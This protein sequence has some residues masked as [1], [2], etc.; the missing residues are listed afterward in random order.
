MAH[1]QQQEQQQ[2]PPLSLIEQQLME[3]QQQQDSMRRQAHVVHF[4][5]PPT[6]LAQ[7][8]AVAPAATVLSARQHPGVHDAGALPAFINTTGMQPQQQDAQQ[9][10]LKRP[11][12]AEQQVHSEARTSQQALLPGI[13]PPGSRGTAAA[14]TAHARAAAAAAQLRQYMAQLM[15]NSVLPKQ[16][17]YHPH[18]QAVAH[19]AA[20]QPFLQAALHQQLQ[21]H[22]LQQQHL[23]QQHQQ[24]QHQQQQQQAQAST[25]PQQ[26]RPHAATQQPGRQFVGSSSDMLQ[27]YATALGYGINTGNDNGDESDSEGDDDAGSD[28]DNDD[29][30][31]ALDEPMR[32]LHHQMTSSQHGMHQQRLL[33][34]LI[35]QQG[36]V[37][38]L[39]D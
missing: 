27:H 3:R 38:W 29:D 37:T 4:S 24:Q 19:Q 6:T 16:P 14:V 10:P 22:Q 39:I 9:P 28:D 17:L 20:S 1:E 7:H 18:H 33:H 35:Q 34:E 11:K 36:C 5:G 26:W 12:H 30:E 21:Q 23:Q 2:P 25:L 13:M 32:A 31:A 15:A 8:A